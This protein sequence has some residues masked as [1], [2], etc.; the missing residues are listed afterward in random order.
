MNLPQEV[1]YTTFV[2]IYSTRDSKGCEYSVVF[3]GEDLLFL[4]FKK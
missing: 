3:G 4:F 1:V 2:L